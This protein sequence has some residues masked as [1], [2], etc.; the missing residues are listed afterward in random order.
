MG[1]F[2]NNL[3]KLD[4]V[5]KPRGVAVMVS[6]RHHCMTTRGVHKHGTQMVTSCM[7][8]AFRD[9]PQLR[10]EFQMMIGMPV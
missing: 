6:S 8:G 9:D 5:L 3:P 1:L 10:R 7:V 2:R 4:Q